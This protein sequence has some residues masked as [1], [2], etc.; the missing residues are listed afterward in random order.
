MSR[1]GPGSVEM[2]N[3]AH[4]PVGNQLPSKIRFQADDRQL[5][6][7]IAKMKAEVICLSVC[8]PSL[9]TTLSCCPHS[10]A[11]GECDICPSSWIIWEHGGMQSI[12]TFKFLSLKA[13]VGHP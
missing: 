6:S 9:H 10:H 4:P 5:N 7:V 11:E 1:C 2:C 3:H 8:L 13:V 12:M